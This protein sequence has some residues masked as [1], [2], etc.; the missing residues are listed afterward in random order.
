MDK[1][2]IITHYFPPSGHTSSERIH[3]WATTFAKQ[4]IK[5]IILTR[6]WGE[7]GNNKELAYI[8]IGQKVEIEN[9]DGYEV[10]ALP[11][12]PWLT[13]KLYLKL[14]HTRLKFIYL[15]VYGVHR[16]L[17]PWLVLPYYRYFNHLKKY[18]DEQLSNNPTIKHCIIS[19]P[20]FAMLKI[21]YAL[22]K[23]HPNVHFI[24]DYRDDWSTNE[25][26]VT[27]KNKYLRKVYTLNDKYAEK[28]WLKAYSLFLSVSDNYVEKIQTLT[29]TKGLTI[30]NGYLNQNYEKLNGKVDPAKFVICYVGTL[31]HTQPIEVFIEAVKELVLEAQMP[32]EVMFI[33]A[34]GK[35][36]KRIQSLI[37]G[38]EQ[39]FK[40]FPR[41]SKQEC[42]VKQDQSDLLLLVAHT[43]LKGTPGSKMY[44]YLALKKSVLVCPSDGE[45]IEQTL[46]QAN[47]GFF[48]SNKEE[49]LIALQKLVQSKIKNGTTYCQPNLVFIDKYDRSNIAIKL[50]EH[51]KS[52]D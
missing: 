19:V 43:G 52:K 24:A 21:G 2:L 12:K 33:G 15:I 27:P 3:S 8:A 20:P 49:C 1:I 26:F 11:F 5:P 17:E 48:A 31:L 9:K 35:Y 32:I 22:K 29:L 50:L 45:I 25:V 18:A 28:K 14:I 6:N 37:K 40:F 38:F 7:G 42:I 36:E 23:M 10:H 34:E 4:G 46:S 41:M 44:E 51:L 39:S 13:L 30:E 16:F 47:V